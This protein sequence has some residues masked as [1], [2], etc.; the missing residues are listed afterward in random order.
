MKKFPHMWKHCL[1]PFNSRSTLLS[2]RT[3]LHFD[4]VLRTAGMR[5][6]P[7]TCRTN[8]ALLGSTGK[9]ARQI[10]TKLPNCSKQDVRLNSD[11]RNITSETYRTFSYSKLNPCSVFQVSIRIHPLF[12]KSFRF[13]PQLS[14]FSPY[15][16]SLSPSILHS[17]HPSLR[18][19]LSCIHHYRQAL[20]KIEFRNQTHGEKMNHRK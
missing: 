15:L 3:A 20:A 17:F 5:A 13:I 8:R 1:E 19:S 10:K 4:H 11:L 18:Q 12:I 2:N 6:D 7:F 16:L 9:Y 14:S